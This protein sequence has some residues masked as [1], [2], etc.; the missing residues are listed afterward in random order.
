ML[1]NNIS[2]NYIL[3]EDSFEETR[4]NLQDFHSFSKTFQQNEPEIIRIVDST[5]DESENSIFKIQIKHPKIKKNRKKHEPKVKKFKLCQKKNVLKQHILQ[6]FGRINS[7]KNIPGDSIKIQQNEEHETNFNFQTILP[8]VMEKNI[9]IGQKIQA[10]LPKFV[11]INSAKTK[12]TPGQEVLKNFIWKANSVR[13]DEF[14]ENKKLVQTIL[15]LNYFTD[16]FMCQFL[17]MNNYNM[18]ETINYCLL[19]K[20][21]LQGEIIDS[22]IIDDPIFR[23]TRNSLYNKFLLR[24]S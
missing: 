5:E 4:H 19:N 23:K 24:K 3:I 8:L 9:R 18:E 10:T 7:S 14:E 17:E 21:K 20:N 16:D 1:T 6:D 2:S 13:K 11:K 22:Y 12:C 15:G